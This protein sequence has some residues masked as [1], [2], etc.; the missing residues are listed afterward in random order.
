M[1]KNRRLL[2]QDVDVEVKGEAPTSRAEARVFGPPKPHVRP[3]PIDPAVEVKPQLKP[4]PPPPVAEEKK[5][6]TKLTHD[7]TLQLI[8]E[9]AKTEDR[10]IIRVFQKSGFSMAQNFASFI[11]KAVH[12][13]TP[14]TWMPRIVGA[15]EYKIGV[16]TLSENQLPTRIGEHIDYSQGG[17]RRAYS[18]AETRRVM[19][20]PD[21][22]G[23]SELLTASSIDADRPTPFTSPSLPPAA[24][25]L[26]PVTPLTVAPPTASASDAWLLARERELMDREQKLAKE[27]A[28]REEN[29]KRIE[30]ETKM[31]HEVARARAESD[32]RF[33]KLESLI[34]RLAD[35]KEPAKNT[36]V[37]TLSALTPLLTVFLQQQHETR[38]AMMKASQDQHANTQ[39]QF[40]EMMKARSG[41]PPEIAVLLDLVKSQG[42]ASTE[43][44]SKI[45]E[46]TG[47]VSKTSIGM[48]EAIADLQLGSQPEQH[49]MMMAVKEGIKALG[50]L[51]QGTQRGAQKIV[52]QQQRQIPENLVRP[53]QPVQ[54]PQ[55]Q[56]AQPQ[57][58][59]QRPTQAQPVPVH[60]FP[61]NGAAPMPTPVPNHP[62]A[63]DG[64]PGTQAPAAATA[65]NEAYGGQN[66]VDL[67]E[68]MIRS[69]ADHDAVATLFFDALNQQHPD[70]MRE[71]QAVEGDIERLIGERLGDWTSD[72]GNLIYL[73]GLERAFTEAAKRSN[74]SLAPET[75]GTDETAEA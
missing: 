54:Q 31:Q 75:D 10:F 34:E 53:Q 7:E 39:L 41:L 64:P 56:A 49:P 47:T 30:L 3:G 12:L 37:E 74:V 59:A 18:E 73:Q 21:W 13:T 11:G 27:M 29:L 22:Q 66:P 44:M 43:M 46:A 40:Q 32:T 65:F 42:S 35:R 55:Q 23:P 9:R 19:S 33:A 2:I 28:A 52:Q 5:M 8:A 68:R 20:L 61:P 58:Q 38:L 67:L 4:Q 26:P 36:M 57:Q 16:F 62:P 69:H 50:A 70:L 72:A 14:E 45:V 6:S 17:P 24:P 63:F 25:Q 1:T 51:T 71:L 48:I 60:Q 15:G